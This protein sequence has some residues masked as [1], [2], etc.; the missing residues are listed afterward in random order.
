ML[1]NQPFARKLQLLFLPM[2]IA[3]LIILSAIVALTIPNA[4]LTFQEEMLELKLNLA[5]TMLEDSYQLLV[6]SG[7]SDNSFFLNTSQ[8]RIVDELLQLDMGDASIALYSNDLEDFLITPKYPE[9]FSQITE[10]SN[11]KERQNTRLNSERFRPNSRV[12]FMYRYFTPWNM[13]MGIEIPSSTLYNPV[14]NMLALFGISNIIFLIGGISVIRRVSKSISRPIQ[15]LAN[16]VSSFGEGN[17]GLRMDPK[18][19]DEIS[20]LATRFNEMAERISGF[21]RDL[22]QKVEDRTTALQENIEVLQQTQRQLIETEKLASLGSVVSGVAHEINT[23]LGVGITSASFLEHMIKQMDKH[24]RNQTLTKGEMEKLL[25]QSLDSLIIL[26]ENLNRAQVLVQSFKEVSADQMVDELRTFNFAEYL[27]EILSSLRNQTKRRVK[28]LTVK[29]PEILLIR[30]HP[31]AYWQ[32]FSNLIQ[33]SLIHAFPEDFQLNPSIEIIFER[34]EESLLIAFS[35]NGVGMKEEIRKSAFE[36]F[37]TT[38]RGKGGTGLGLNIVYNL[39]QRL[40]GNITLESDD[41]GTSL[42]MQIPD[43]VVTVDSVNQ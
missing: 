40:R 19:K 41:R 11:V 38:R 6:A 7:M 34:D 33:N 20:I 2:V 42:Y 13:I 18:G 39:V 4:L 17:L 22:E 3:P 16:G 27:G 30:S 12:M 32:I 9:E 10:Q 5:Y 8:N 21:T 36:P 24:F 25:S 26:I 37:I 23:P 15:N 28:Y 43:V 35:D 1:N 29:G 31:G 14:F